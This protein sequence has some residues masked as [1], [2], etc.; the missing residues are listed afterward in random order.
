MCGFLIIKPQTTLHHAGWCGVVQYYLRCSTVMPFCGRFWCGFCGLCGLCGLVNTPSFCCKMLYNCSWW[1]SLIYLVICE[2][3]KI[4]GLEYTQIG[5][6]VQIEFDWWNW[7]VGLIEFIILNYF[8]TCV[9]IN[10]SIYY[11]LNKFSRA[12][13]YTCN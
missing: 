5:D 1:F 6:F 13:V 2:K 7:L 10:W 4:L 12:A 11:E 8:L 3:L 9:M